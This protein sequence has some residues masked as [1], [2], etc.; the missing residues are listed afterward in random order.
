M[1]LSFEWQNRPLYN[2]VA[3][4]PG[5]TRPDEWIVYGNHHDAWVMGADD[6]ISGAS[7]LMETARGLGE[8]LKSG[9][10]PS[11]T[12]ILAL[13]DG[14]E[15]GLLGSTEWAEKHKAE[16]QQKAVA[17][18]NTD[19]TGK[20]WLSAGGSHGLQQFLGEVAKDV[21][22]PRTGK[23]VFEEARRRAILGEP[24]AD[25]AV[26][27]KDAAFRI[28]PLGSGSDYTPF[29]QHL[30]LSALNLS[31]GGESPGGVYHSAYDT[32]KWYQTHSDSDYSYGRALSQITGSL[33]LRL[34]EAPVLPFQFT[35]TADTLMRYVVELEKLAESKKDS[36]IDMKPVRNAV[37]ALRQ[38]G[39]AYEKAYASLPKVN[40]AQLLGRK[41]LQQLNML[42]LTS[43]QKLGNS[44]GLPR[45]DWFK[46]QIY[47]PGFY[48]GYGV[49]TMPQ[50]REG[51]EEN[52]FTEAQGGV[53]TVSAAINALAAQVTDAARALET[54]V[55]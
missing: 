48:T 18:I 42:L 35:D 14:E 29:L 34:S 49:K 22:D 6:P 5:T 16:L 27:E 53:R 39:Q 2:V 8:L 55:R 54:V 36:K 41:E 47:A 30:T 13:W 33:I 21:M 17:Y 19:S 46:H 37:E 51:L 26:A 40:T 28:A 10:R 23:P 45:R 50:I 12:I 3:R 7:S 24:E 38:A 44:D 32:V 9:W 52:R 31:F 1:K 20:G 4:I 43:E 25:R 15:W 11:R